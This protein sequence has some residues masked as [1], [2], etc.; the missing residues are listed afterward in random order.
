LPTN[1]AN[2]ARS[3]APLDKAGRQRRARI[4]AYDSW[5]KTVDRTKRTAAG[6]QAALDRFQRQVDPEGVLSPEEREKRAEAARKAHFARM[7]DR[8]VKARQAKR[9]QAS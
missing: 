5:A 9:K 1:R 2:A 6:R 7:A 4:A 8:S 3:G